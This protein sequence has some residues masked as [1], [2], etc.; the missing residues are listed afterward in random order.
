MT[1]RS[2]AVM[3]AG[4]AL[5]VGS[6]VVWFAT[7]PAET[8]GDPEALTQEAEPDLPLPDTLSDL[9]PPDRENA[10]PEPDIATPPAQ[11][12]GLSI[13]A[14]SV[15]APVDPVALEDDGGMEVPHDI[16]RI[17][18][19]EP[20]VEVG[21]PT[22]TAVLSGHV[23]SREQGEG[24][25]FDLRTLE[26]DDRVH[27]EHADGDISEWRVVARTVYA[28]DELPIADIFTRFG[29]PR[30]VLITCGGAFDNTERSY[31]DN[32]VVYAE[33]VDELAA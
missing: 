13:P 21:S 24:A 3:V 6:P 15:D 31:E 23:D 33:P 16:D 4:L 32:V 12:V 30:L 20:G 29:E 14:I 9:T 19:Y 25:F 26:Q 2:I 28:K 7:Q 11:P 17:G 1:A 10:T 27:V 18:W 8:V 5:L 22:G